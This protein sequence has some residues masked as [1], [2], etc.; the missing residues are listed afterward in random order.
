MSINNNFQDD[1]TN[2]ENV[3]ENIEDSKSNGLLENVKKHI[4]DTSDFIQIERDNHYDI[5]RTLSVSKNKTEESTCTKTNG[6]DITNHPEPSNLEVEQPSDAPEESEET[7]THQV[8]T[9]DFD[10]EDFK[11]NLDEPDEIY[12]EIPEDI[13]EEETSSIPKE[14]PKLNLPSTCFTDCS[15]P[16]PEQHE[17]KSVKDRM[18]LSTDDAS[19]LL[20]TQTVTSPMLTPSEEN[21][22]F[23]KGFQQES[24]Q[25][26]STPKT[27]ESDDL[28]TVDDV[29][30]LNELE[31]PE[32]DEAVYENSE[33]FKRPQENIYENVET[34]R[35]SETSLEVEETPFCEVEETH[36][37]AQNNC[38]ENEEHVYENLEELKENGE[39]KIHED[40]VTEC[41][42]IVKTLTSRFSSLVN[43]EDEKGLTN[44]EAEDL[45]ELK[46]LNIMKH[47]SKFENID[48]NVE[49]SVNLF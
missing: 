33:Y 35:N 2:Q 34:I 27:F 31:A 43:V 21:I 28:D 41:S 46:M 13:P 45:S 24:S 8:K 22:D 7:K 25:I 47:I 5:P 15:E 11:T 49:V 36:D 20:F 16:E 6:F 48:T 37:V 18:F 14:K 38:V 32:V 17:I 29:P 19:C 1:L 44:R 23:L 12:T 39:D 9:D 26:E 30:T 10:Y 3:Y 4:T 40:V 42:Q